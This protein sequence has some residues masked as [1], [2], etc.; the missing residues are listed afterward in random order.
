MNAS[1]IILAMS[2][3]ISTSFAAVAAPVPPAQQFRATGQPVTPAPDGTIFCE[4]E[5][6]RIEK[7]GWQSLPWGANYYA[8]TFANTFLSRKAFLGAPA[9]CEEAVATITI[10]VKEAGKYLVLV[11]YE[12]AYRFETQFKVKVE[13]GGATKLDR[14]YGA[15]DNLKIWA[16]REKLKK[17]VGWGWGAVENVVWEGHD[18][19][20]ELQPGTAKLSLIAGKQPGPPAKRNVDL[21]MLTRDEAQ[22][23]ERIEKENYLPLDGWLTQSGD[24][25]L[26]AHNPGT[27]P[28]TVSADKVQEHSPYWVH[29]RNWKP[30]KVEVAPGQATEWLD[31]GGLWDSLSDA[32]GVLKATGK[33]RFEFGV[34]NADGK[35]ES[36]RTLEG[37]NVTY[38]ADADARYTRRV[39]TQEEGV[40]EL[41]AYLHKLP[42]HGK[43]PS[44]TLIYAYSSI[45]EFGPMFGLTER[46][47]G[48]NKSYVDW[49]G[50][51]AAKLEETCQKLTP[52]QR[53][54]I[55]VV[56]LGDE[57]GLPAPD[58]NAAKD[59]FA[60]FL[61]GNGIDPAKYAYTTDAAS[62]Q[63]N[64]GAFYWS[65]R[66]LHH[67]GIQK[68]KELTDVLRKNLPNAQ[69]GANYS[70]H[71]GGSV[72][73]YLGPV[74]QWV[75]CFRE[76]GMTLPWS[77][78]YI[79][80]LPVGSP[81]MNGIN[82]DLFRAGNRGKP[83]R[84]ILYYAMPHTPGN[85]PAMWRRLYHNALGHGMT[86]INLFEFHPVWI[87]YTENHTS[88]PELYAMV[89]RTF[90]ELGL[91]E[92]IVQSSQVRPAQVGLW[93]SET[94]DIWGDNAGSFAAAK[95]ALYTAILHQEVPLDFVVEQDA[96]DGTLGRYKVLYLTDAHVTKA[97]SKKIA[98]WVEKGGVL[99]ATAGAGMFDET[100]QPNETLRALLGVNR[101]ALDAPEG[102]N[103]LYIKQDLPFAKE[104]TTI[105]GMT[106]VGV[107]SRIELKGAETQGTFA[108]G[109]P[110]ITVRK[111]GKGRAIYTAFLP[112]LS[113]YQP[114]IPLRPV[115][116]GSTDDAMA[117]LMPTAFDKAASGL[118]R[119][120]LTAA[121]VEPAITAS[122][123]LVE[124]S[125][126]ES[127]K[128][129]LIV[130]T[131]WTSEPRK[132]LQLTVHFPVKAGKVELAGGGQVKVEKKDGKT[133]LTFDLDI[134]DVVILR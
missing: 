99:F 57:I 102:S 80:Q 125:I 42:K 117:H 119:Q 58:A 39:R 4:A 19:Y 23:K 3:F 29:I 70:P 13:Q 85:T 97:G 46:V 116:R 67:Y 134:A 113:Y 40:K 93:F 76:D 87:A 22:V 96:L 95:R 48:E 63:S 108:D 71:H 1:Q 10:D 69:I 45:K 101:T 112:G 128:G 53:K 47:S 86:I 60:A 131:N 28:V 50:Q 51:D 66:Y 35:I 62:K 77:E 36:V 90:R 65:K 98:E 27:A 14:L 100:N 37:T 106:V 118:I 15:R 124:T 49:R 78:D 54:A 105:N 103:V 111:A 61:K 104:I 73:A 107:R 126:L 115:D 32:Q 121:G 8:A 11:R 17:E 127:K 92:E 133:T 72:H 2:L 74:F 41:L 89:L 16:F 83:D 94:G 31:L 91:Y 6:F 33:C 88:F 12:A 25:W 30:I 68:M 84:K 81:Q 123:P 109:L 5:E 52:E 21:V 56:S 64:P 75:T 34:K 7:S 9:E 129:T 120:P 44:Q 59:G 110:A 38:I 20:A 18:A 55:R 26:K 24:V 130:V 132:G 82:L 114:A 79:W 122:A 43:V